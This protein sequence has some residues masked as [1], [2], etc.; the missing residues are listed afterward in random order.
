[1]CRSKSKQMI[2]FTEHSEIHGLR[3]QNTLKILVGDNIDF[4]YL[5][6]GGPEIPIK[7]GHLVNWAYVIRGVEKIPEGQI[8][9]SE[10]SDKT[11]PKLLSIIRIHVIPGVIPNKLNN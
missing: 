7:F 2:T 11:E 9:F 6:I 10:V 1:M 3:I 8:L 5:Q 4:T